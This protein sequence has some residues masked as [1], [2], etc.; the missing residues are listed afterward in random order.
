MRGSLKQVILF[1]CCLILF[2]ASFS[3]T[4][5]KLPANVDPAAADEKFSN[6]NFLG[7]L[8]DYLFLLKKEPNN[9]K[10][11]YRVG[12]CY[13]NTNINKAKAISYLEAES[14]T[15]KPDYD[16]WFNLGKAYHYANRFDDAVKMFNKYKEIA[17]GSSE[18]KK[19]VDRYIQ[20]CYN[21]KELIK[22]PLKVT[23][24]NLGKNVN[25]PY[26]DFQPFVP[27]DESYLVFTSR[28]KEGS[29]Q[30]EDGSYASSVFIS[31]VVNGEF[32]K[33]KSIGPP[34]NTGEGDEEVVGLSLSGDVMLLVYD[35]AVSFADLFMAKAD[36]KLNFK[37]AEPFDKN[38][39]SSAQE[40]SASI[41]PDGNTLYFTSTRSGGY[42]GS[43]IY[44]S[45]KLPNGTWALPQNL[46]PEINTD[47]DEDFPNISPDGQTLYFSSTGHTSMGGYDIF[48]ATWSET[49][50]KWTNIKNYG[51]PINTSDDDMNLRLSTSGKYGY[52][53]AVREGGQGDQDI[54]RVDFNDVEPNYSLVRGLVASAD[55]SRKLNQ[56][57][58]SISVTNN[59]AKEEYGNYVPNP[60]SG[61]YVMILPPGDYTIQI[62][63]NGFEKYSE[64]FAVADKIGIR[65]E[66]EKNIT[67][68]P[69]EGAIE[70]P[71]TNTKQS[72]GN[73]KTKPK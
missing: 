52:I 13:L 8:K 30:I 50:N 65:Q 57:D 10:Y 2:F 15:E 39:N 47:A 18:N 32:S 67:L 16:V 28:R 23:F 71:K 19:Q 36:K 49:M 43:D 55:T 59:K 11:S 33:A 6:N 26:A 3:Q 22:F 53:A 46:G 21:A 14:K 7:A 31:K 41:S 44:V 64:K 5:F 56:A 61:K 69:K 42:G 45:H 1:C 29:V 63:V 9:D 37:K 4:D 60:V 17:K 70:Q 34:I 66:M 68:L 51:Y 38:I 73:T 35:N 62:E 27:E 72:G 58:V 48:K 20:Y 12:I 24:N 54:Y 25:S 40:I